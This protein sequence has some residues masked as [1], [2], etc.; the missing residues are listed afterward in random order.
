MA[1]QAGMGQLKVPLVGKRVMIALRLQKSAGITPPSR[2]NCKSLG[3]KN[4]DGLIVDHSNNRSAITVKRNRPRTY[5][6]RRLW[7]FPMVMGILPVKPLAA[8]KLHKTHTEQWRAHT[9]KQETKNG[10]ESNGAE[11]VSRSIDCPTFAGA[12]N[13]DEE[14]KNQ[15]GAVEQKRKNAVQGVEVGQ[16]PHRGR[17]RTA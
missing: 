15:A 17:N 14:K 9:A 6:L 11:S 16:I 5:K 1:Q 12:H 4:Q 10:K 13:N 8:A 3:E 2:F 7:R